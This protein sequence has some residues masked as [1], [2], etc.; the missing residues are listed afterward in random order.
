MSLQTDRLPALLSRLETFG[1]EAEAAVAYI[2]GRNVLLSFHAQATGARWRPGRRIEL[3][4]AYLPGAAQEPYL[5]SL[6]I[7]EVRHL[8][9]G[10]LVALSVYGEL[11]AWQLQFGFIHGRTG[12]YHDRAEKD[13]ILGELMRVPLLLKRAPLKVARRLMR[14]YAGP[15]YRI[16]LLPLF[17]MGREILWRLTGREPGPG[18]A[19]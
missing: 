5:A 12:R 16:D 11:E 9:Q 18:I 2:R 19:H 15:R 6:V 7:H 4:P 14:E 1:P 17:P 3:N 13:R 8:Q 10:G